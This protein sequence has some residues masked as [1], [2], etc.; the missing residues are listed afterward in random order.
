MEAPVRENQTHVTQF[1]LLGFRE[2]KNLQ[3][4]LFLGFLAIYIVTMAGNLLILVLVVSDQHLHTP[5]YFFLG[6]LSCLEIC[7]SS[8]LIPVLLTTLLWDGKVISF[9]S[10]FLQLFF[11]G[12][13][14][15]AECYLLSVMSYDRYLAICKPLHYATAMN[16]RKCVQLAAVSWTNGVIGIS[17]IMAAMLQLTYC[18]PNEIDHYFCDSVPLKKLSCSDTNLVEHVNLTLLFIYTMP[19]FLLTLASY[20][21][22]IRAILRIS[23]TTGRQ[24][25]FSTCSSHLIVVSTYYGSLTAVYLLP[26][27]SSIN[28]AFSLLYTILPPLVNPLIYSLRNKEVKRAFRKAK[29]R[30]ANFKIFQNVLANLFSIKD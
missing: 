26:K 13:C 20:I 21:C 2:L 22:I 17:I 28:K 18:G 10:C 30:I 16:T 3:V 25:A 23:S 7:Y 15:G 12:Y 19:P 11:F 24:K 14:L 1:I 8:T 27:S 29:N 4:L 5:M 6:N 9:E